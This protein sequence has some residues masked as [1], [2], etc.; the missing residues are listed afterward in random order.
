MAPEF[1][2]VDDYISSFPPEVQTVLQ[3]ARETIHAAAPGLQESISYGIP[4]FRID[5]R[6]VVYL[7]GWRKHISIY[8]IPDLDEALKS[9]M[10][11]YLSGKGTAKFPLGKPIPHELIKALVERLAARR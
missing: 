8:P 7:G 6:P 5:G 2:S 9:N 3:A 4:T 10:A 1:E 11:P